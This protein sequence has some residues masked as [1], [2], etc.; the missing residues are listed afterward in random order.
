MK[1]AGQQFL[2]FLCTMQKLSVSII[3]FNEESNIGRCI[4]SVLPIADEIIVIDSYSSDRTVAISNSFPGVTLVENAFA[5]YIEQKNFAISRCRNEYILSLDADEALSPELLQSIKQA[6]EN[7][8]SDGY[9]M[10][11]LT[12]YC[13]KWIRHCGWYPDVKMRLFNRKAVWGGINPHDKIILPA[14]SKISRLKGDILHYSYNT[15]NDHINQIRHFTEIGAQEAYKNGVRS[16]FLK[17][18]YKPKV[19]FIR[20]FIFKLGFLD[21]F[22]GYVVCYSS[23]FATFL[24]YVR[25][26]MLQ[27]GK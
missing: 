7:F 20:D 15:I 9:T 17:I 12:N 22:Y 3:A 18:I 6:G 23:A 19:K 10:S 21:G 2:C 8:I 27:K 4:E 5:G 14:G 1:Y 16:S 13:G 25:I 11:R 24:K 26:R